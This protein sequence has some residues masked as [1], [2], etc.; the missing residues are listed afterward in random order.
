M[1]T[2]GGS[3]AFP[4]VDSVLLARPAHIYSSSWCAQQSQLC[5]WSPEQAVIKFV[6]RQTDA[7]LTLSQKA[8]IAAALA[9]E[10]DVVARTYFLAPLSEHWLVTLKKLTEPAGNVPVC[11]QA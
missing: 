8:S 7:A 10:T 11:S 3:C 6:W 5:R 2:E 4:T 9:E 1:A